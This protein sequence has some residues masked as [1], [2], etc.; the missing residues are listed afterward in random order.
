MYNHAGMRVAR[1]HADNK[2]RAVLDPIRDVL[3]LDI[4]YANP[5]DHV[6]EDERNNCTI[7]ERIRASYN[8]LPCHTLTKTMVKVLVSESAK[9]LNFFLLDMVY[10]IIIAHA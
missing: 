10:R 7:K 6:L 2:F 8:R 4:N 1:I 3:D 9:K 5:P